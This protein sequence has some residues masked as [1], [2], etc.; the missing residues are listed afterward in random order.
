MSS[1]KPIN[2]PYDKNAVDHLTKEVD[3]SMIE[4]RNQMRKNLNDQVF[5]PRWDTTLRFQREIA[6]ERLRKVTEWKLF[7]V[8]DFRTDP[9]SIFAAHEILSYSDP[10][11][12]TKMT[13]QFNLFGGT[14]LKLGTKKHHDLFLN[15]IDS[16][17]KIG[18]FALTELG[19]GN[20]AI[21]METT[22]IFDRATG[23]FVINTPT[24]LAQK[25]WITNSAV[26]ATWSIVFAQLRI[27]DKE[28]GIHAFLCRIRDDLMK[29]MPGVTI[30]DMGHKFGC[31]GVDNGKLSFDNVRVPRDN[32][33]NAL[34]DVDEKGNFTSKIHSRRKR[35]LAV[36]DQLLSGRI[37]IAATA[38]ASCKMSLALAIRYSASRKAVGPSGK[39]DTPILDYQLQQ[40]TLIPLLARTYAFNFALRYVEDRYAKQTEQDAHEILIFCCAIKPLISWH[41]CLTSN[42]CRERCGGQGYLSV[43]RFGDII[44]GIHAAITAEGD[45]AVLMQKV[46]K[47]L[48]TL[49]QTG[50]RQLNSPDRPHDH[51]PISG[52]AQWLNYLIQHRENKTLQDLAMEFQQQLGHGKPIYQVWMKEESD[53]IQGVARAFGE[54]LAHQHFSNFIHKFQ[55][56]PKAQ[57]LAKPVS[58]LGELYTLSCVHEDVGWYAS[59]GV[60]NSSQI[61]EIRSRILQLVAEIAP[62]AIML[63]DSFGIPDHQ[64]PAPIAFNWEKYNSYD[65]RGEINDFKVWSKL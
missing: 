56:D 59:E 57:T 10:S 63:S 34:S 9:R 31:N 18:C 27:D 14:V 37:C 50:K 44:A 30:E 42:T 23:E 55:A 19:F 24:T 47:E 32:L 3:H 53:R 26:H 65:N 61:K 15:D 17:S 52:N 39:S 20:N 6:L 21:E 33:L 4:L 60:L 12:V 51:L 58:L 25:Y 43:N 40:R 22:A 36:A 64:M 62:F 35:F 11:S 38:L 54:S 28:Y 46:T 41:G 5:N 8:K 13:V 1:P 16:L 48:L 7:S 29:P 45:N 2:A 49:V